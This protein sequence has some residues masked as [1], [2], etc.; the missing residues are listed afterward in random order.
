LNAPDGHDDVRRVNVTSQ[1]CEGFAA[2]LAAIEVVVGFGRS[3]RLLRLLDRV[4]KVVGV[5]IDVAFNHATRD[6]AA[7]LELLRRLQSQARA[8]ASAIKD[9]SLDH[10][11]RAA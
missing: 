1:V 4:M 6:R 9:G 3:R 2:E 11:A 5:Q 8:I 10:R 7:E